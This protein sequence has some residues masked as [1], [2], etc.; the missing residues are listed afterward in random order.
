MADPHAPAMPEQPT[1]S[2]L[3]QLVNSQSVQIRNLA[4]LIVNVHQ[5]LVRANKHQADDIRAN[6]ADIRAIQRDMA[7]VKVEVEALKAWRVTHQFTCP[8][9]GMGERQSTKLQ[10]HRLME[11]AFNLGELDGIIY[12]LGETPD[13]L[14]GST[15]S[16][17]VRAVIDHFERRGRMGDLLALLQRLRPNITWP[18]FLA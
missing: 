2:D 10:L 15:L 11:S 3:Y 6:A 13:E 17:K 8:F 12:D 16:E 9:V 14:G 4:D 18:L 1:L 7:A 5:E